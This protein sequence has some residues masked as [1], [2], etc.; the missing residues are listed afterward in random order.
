MSDLNSHPKSY[1]DFKALVEGLNP[2]T[3]D[4]GRY[5]RELSVPELGAESP[6]TGRFDH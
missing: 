4:D 3:K 5:H 6:T 1:G 2:A